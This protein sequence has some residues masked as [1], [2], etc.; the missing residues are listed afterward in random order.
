M[1]YTPHQR[2]AITHLDG[3]LQIIACAGAGKT[4]TISA[5]I[6]NILKD[7]K[8]DG[9]TPANIV[10][11]TF[12]EKAAGELKDRIHRLCKEE[13]DTDR[14]LADLFVGTIHA[15]CLNLLQAPPLY[16]F[17]KYTVLTDVQQRLLIDRNSSRSGLTHVPLLSGGNLERWKDSRLYQQLLAICSDGHAD[18]KNLPQGVKEAVVKYYELLDSKKYLDYTRIIAQAVDELKLNTALRAKVA[19]QL[20]YLVVDEYQDVNPLQE[21]L[22]RELHNLGAN[23]SVVGDDDQTIYQ[24]RGSDVTNIMAFAKRYANVHQVPL[25]DNYRSSTGIVLAARQVIENNNPERLDKRMESTEAQPTQRGDVLAL[26][27]ENPDE[28]ASWIANKIKLLQGTFYEDKKHSVSRGLTFG[29]VAILLRSVRNDAARILKALEAAEIPYIVGGM[30]HLFETLEVQAMREVFFFLADFTPNGGRL[31]TG[32]QLENI[33]RECNLGLT[34]KRISAGLKLLK[35]RKAKIG[36]EMD[37]ELYLQRVYLDFLEAIEL[38]EETITQVRGNNRGEI[39]YFNLGKFSQVISDFEHINFRT[40]PNKLY[41]DFAGFLFHQAPDYYPEGWEE[42]ASATPDAVRVMTV[43]QAKG[44]QWPAVFIPSLRQNR[45]PSR[46]R[47]GRSIWHIIPETIV[48]NAEQYKGTMEDERRLFYVALTRA[49][50]Y[51][52]CSWAPVADNQQQRTVSKFFRELTSSQYVLTNEPKSSLPQQVAPKPRKE[53]ITLALTFSELK[54]YFECPYLFKLRFLYG[55]DAPISRALGYG[56]SLHDALAEIHAES[57]KK[58]IPSIDD[59]PRLVS[60]HLHL[61]FANSLV[62]ENLQRAAHKALTYYLLAHGENLKKLEHVEKIVELKLAEGIVV[63]G[64]IDLIRKTDIDELVVVDFKSDERAQTE[65]ISQR[66][67][68][69]YVLGYEQL[70]GRRADL[71]EIHNLDKGGAKREVVNE[72]FLKSTTANIM[73]AGS[74]IRDNHLP[75][76]LTWGEKCLSCEMVN[77]CRKR[78]TPLPSA[79]A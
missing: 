69:I 38:R 50:K 44:M 71:I 5:R 29:D 7:K 28:E 73:E 56:K 9:V 63:S 30:N 8:R 1:N 16:K 4:Q 37:A 22:I 27:F 20:K 68:H 36:R 58:T 31:V 19:T 10:A 75:R 15:Y 33:L 57:L 40:N 47:G 45:F 21:M 24:W 78:E 39:V 11:L 3:N 18:Q 26:T 54:Y 43:H 66:Q 32:D 60:D 49:E 46:R 35:R 14:G 25:N 79:A 74:N 51:L 23:L 53:N 2:Q 70:S 52:F 72:T 64:R 61:P 48:R 34:S 6:V 42:R 62:L 55:F 17:L 41:V 77:V 76:L 12:T 13:L 59:V 67:L 65:D